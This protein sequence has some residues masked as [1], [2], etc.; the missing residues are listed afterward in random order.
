MVVELEDTAVAEREDRRR[1]IRAR[2]RRRRLRWR[3]PRRPVVAGR[4]IMRAPLSL[5]VVSAVARRSFSNGSG[6]G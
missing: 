1:R 4:L 6:G 3:W 2:W 5:V